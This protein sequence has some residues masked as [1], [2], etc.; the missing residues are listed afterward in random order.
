MAL[1][2]RGSDEFSAG[3]ATFLKGGVDRPQ[4]LLVILSA[5]KLGPFMSTLVSGFAEVQV[6]DPEDAYRPAVRATAR[7]LE[8]L[9]S[10]PRPARV[11]TEP[12]VA[13]RGAVELTDHL[14]TEAAANI[15]FEAYPASI[16]CAY[17][18]DALSDKFVA[19]CKRSHP[20]LLHGDQAIPSPAFTEPR[21]LIA[22]TP[23]IQAPPM[24]AD[25]FRCDRPADLPGGAG[26]APV[27]RDASRVGCRTHP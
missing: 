10:D 1:V 18:A 5:S 15:A 17:D 22:R 20:F 11:I 26:L 27:S 6:V 14:R 23:S 21:R 25:A 3:A 8:F 4:R 16:L 2:Y 9:A 12:P 13:E 24:W 19:G 7:V